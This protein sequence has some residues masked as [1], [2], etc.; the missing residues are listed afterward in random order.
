MF[1]IDRY[2]VVNNARKILSKKI[3]LGMPKNT[4][5]GKIKEFGS[6]FYFSDLC[7]TSIRLKDER[8]FIFK[9]TYTKGKKARLRITASGLKVTYSPNAMRMMREQYS[10]YT[11]TFDDHYTEI[12]FPERRVGNMKEMK[13]AL[14]AD[15]K[16]WND[17]GI[18]SLFLE[19]YK[20]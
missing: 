18:Y 20:I 9:Y 15:I 4:R 7:E 8:L 16:Y 12:A 14:E 5:N 2:F 17:S 6:N 19:L 13:K 10:H 11:F 1:L 3:R